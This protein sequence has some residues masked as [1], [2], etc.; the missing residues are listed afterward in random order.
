MNFDIWKKLKK[1]DF[2]AIYLLYGTESFLL[3][4][5]KDLL[6]SNALLEEEK[7]FNLSVFDLEE[8]PL[9]VAMEDAET[10]PFMGDKRIV[11]LQNPYFLTAEKGKEKVEH[12]IP[13]LE[14]YIKQPAPFT[15][16][17][18]IAPYEKLD[19]R[20][21]IVKQ[22]K[23]NAEVLASNAL[24]EKE[25][26]QWIKERVTSFDV[27]ISDHAIS[28]LIQVAGTNLMIITKEIDKMCLYVGSKGNITEETVQLLVSR[29]LEQNIFALIDKV[30]NRKLNEA[31]RIFYDL[32]Q[33]NEEPI[34]ILS[35]LAT[36]FRLIYQAKELSRRG[37]GQQQI[38]GNIKVHP[39]RVKLAL[40]QANLFSDIELLQIINSLAEADY[41]MKNGKK[42][43][44]L[45][46]ELF[47]MNLA[48]IK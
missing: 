45:I 35:L 3:N 34:K 31:L 27:M 48:N 39:F 4:E 36:Q 12:Y 14:E 43:K 10:L 30:V 8:T 13:K 22:L 33:N 28:E 38:A 11:I 2:S 17:V 44:K 41:E 18:L 20:K 37:Y 46:L 29:S 23:A 42:D 16:L 15:I 24:S 7:D 47:I 21:K 19:E 26:S 9:E 6:V 32:L 25:I 1:K 5:T 40:G